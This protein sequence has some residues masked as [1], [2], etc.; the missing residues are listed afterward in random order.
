[1]KLRI[2][3]DLH[4]EHWGVKGRPQKA[5]G[6]L[7][8]ILPPLETDKESILILAGDTG[9][10][11]DLDT[12]RTILKELSSR[13]K[14]VLWVAGNH[15]WYCGDFTK[16]QATYKSLL[17]EFPNIKFNY[18]EDL[19][20]ITFLLTTL[21]TGFDNGSPLEMT[22]AQ[23]GMN[24]YKWITNGKENL[25]PY[26]TLK[27]H[28]YSK[29]VLTEGLFKAEKDQRKVIIVTHHC[30]SLKSLSPKFKGGPLDHSFASNLE[31]LMEEF[32][33]LIW[34]HGHVHQ[35]EDYKVHNTRV[36][37]NPYG[38]HTYERTGFKRNL[39][40]EV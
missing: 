15:E 3:S 25:T 26:D 8:N 40:I 6:V 17:E 37:C 21:W 7:K 5:L 19:E 14:D 18:R 35:P 36:L 22:S 33:P 28:N 20:G 16:D 2:I 12:Y 4:C 29:F 11:S 38:Y 39:V 23:F 34:V 1:M 32:N 13:F 9:D 30:P 31:G 24:D 27:E 10:L